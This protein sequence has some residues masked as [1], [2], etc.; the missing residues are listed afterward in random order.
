[1]NTF[2]V[3]TVYL[4]PP[5]VEAAHYDVIPT[6]E[7]GKAVCGLFLDFLSENPPEFRKALPFL[8]KGSTELQW[9]AADGGVA[10]AAFFEENRPVSMGVLISGLVP[11]ADEQMLASIHEAIFGEQPA[12]ML[13]APER[14]LM[15]NVLFPDSVELHPQVQL[16][17]TAL[18]SVYF[19]VIGEMLAQSTP[20]P[21]S[22]RQ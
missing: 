18:A 5:K 8:K 19:R 2:T 9:A 7:Q 20:G 17:S 14:P 1:M 6:N 22:P 11:E 10:F 3:R 12:E 13:E 4:D 21:G 15:L 16:L